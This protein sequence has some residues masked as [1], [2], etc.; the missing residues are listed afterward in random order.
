MPS[1]LPCRQ[2]LP[3]LRVVKVDVWSGMPRPLVTYS[4][5]ME[6]VRFESN[7]ST[8]HYCKVSARFH[9]LTEMS[10]DRNGPTEAARPNRPDR[11][12]A[13][14]NGS[15]RKVLFLEFIHPV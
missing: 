6:G 2:R 13:D 9:S 7:S 11:N 4:M 1:K 3:L 14:R 8:L 12:G 5:M 15:D 10:R